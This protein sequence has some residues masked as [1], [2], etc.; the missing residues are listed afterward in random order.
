MPYEIRR[1]MNTICRCIVIDSVCYE[2]E[3]FVV[4]NSIWQQF[5]KK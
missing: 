5:I 1:P 4:C 2:N 3:G